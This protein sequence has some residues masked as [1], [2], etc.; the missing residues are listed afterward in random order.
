MNELIHFVDEINAYFKQRKKEILSEPPNSCLWNKEG[1]PFQ[2]DP[3]K[4]G[5]P[6]REKCSSRGEKSARTSVFT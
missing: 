5:G 1:S 2:R 6:E 4:R 3:I